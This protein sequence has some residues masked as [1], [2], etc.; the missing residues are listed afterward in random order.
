MARYEPGWYLINMKF[1]YNHPHIKQR[2]KSLRNNLTKE[3]IILWNYLK[4][5]KIIYKF[6]RQASIGYYIADF[7]CPKYRY[8][9]ELDGEHHLANKQ[10]DAERDNYLGSNGCTVRRFWNGQ[11]HENLDEI[12]QIIRNDLENL[13]KYHP[14]LSGTPPKLGGD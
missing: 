1:V 9:I 4:D 5:S 8:V 10:Y 11:I 7:Y 13:T 12:L 14:A 2:R 6:R 3:E